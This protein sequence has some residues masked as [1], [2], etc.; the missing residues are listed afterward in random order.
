MEMKEGNG[1]KGERQEEKGFKLKIEKG[2][3]RKQEE[4]KSGLKT[5]KFFKKI[6]Y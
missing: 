5:G 1:G 3:G 4:W 6:C 2:E